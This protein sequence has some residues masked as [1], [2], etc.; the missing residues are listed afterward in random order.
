MNFNLNRKKKYIVIGILCSV[1]LHIFVLV[2]DVSLDQFIQ[3]VEKTEKKEKKIKIVFKKTEKS[4]KQIVNTSKSD[5]KIKP[6]DSK[7]LSHSNQT[8][9]RQT[10]ASQIGAFKEAGKGQKNALNKKKQEMAKKQA[11]KVKK[12]IAKKLKKKINFADLAFGKTPKKIKEVVSNKGIKHGKSG[13]TG[14]SAANDFVE[15]IPLGDMTKLNT[16]E[17]KYYG[18]YFRIKQKL[19]QHWGKSLKEKA[20]NIMR[21]NRRMPASENHI[22]SLSIYIDQMGNIVEIIVRGTSGISELDNS[23]IESFNKAGPFPNPPKGLVKNGVAKIDWDF[24]VKS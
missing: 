12:K 1:A 14:F 22:T 24:V 20:H 10:V 21:S 23:A 18:F 8:Q 15:E 3:S 16:V 13:K 7:F 5:H 17:Y 2:E 4:D 19:E 9:D 6:K 11:K